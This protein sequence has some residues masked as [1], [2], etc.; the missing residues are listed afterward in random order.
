MNNQQI[1]RI[2][3]SGYKSI[4]NCNLNLKMINILIGSNGAG[5]SNFLS[6]F[7]LLQDIVESN[8]QLHVALAGGANSIL[9]KGR[10]ATDSINVRFQFGNN[11]YSFNLIPTDTDGM[12]FKTENFHYLDR[13]GN[14]YIRSIGRGNAES[15]WRK[16][17]LTE[18]D[19]YIQPIFEKQ[20]WKL[21]HFHDTS[22]SSKVKQTSD[23]ANNAELQFNAGN[24]SAFLLR[25]KT[26]YPKNYLSI[27]E[28]IKLVA[29]FFSD[30]YLE[31]NNS[32]IETTSL[33]WIQKGVEDIFN[34]NQLSDGTIR[35]ICLAT[36]LLQPLELQPQTIIIDEP[37]LGLHPYAISILA[38]LIKS[39][40]INKQ[41]IL[42]TQSIELLNE[43]S[44]SDI[45]VVNRTNEGTIFQR[46]NE[47]DLKA[48]LESDYT[49]GDLWKKNVF[50]G[51]P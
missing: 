25:L 29:P 19:K 35:F 22:K 11:G 16:G 1:T 43:F 38:E 26:Q 47:N 7:S 28:T 15:L 42:S 27:I 18:Y 44:V 45:I 40:A 48:W 33:R 9:Y 46:L 20:K 36:L 24:L 21:Y 50:G 13:Y 8:L 51:R 10:K 23:I 17:T 4:K 12:I 3:I 41:I 31:P 39:T 2:D 5:K 37:E 14:E 32:N 34:V 6:L 49:I 30:F